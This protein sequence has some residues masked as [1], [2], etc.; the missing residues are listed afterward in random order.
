MHGDDEAAVWL[1]GI[2]GWERTSAPATGISWVGGRHHCSA[3]GKRKRRRFVGGVF[4]QRCYCAGGAGGLRGTRVRG[5]RGGA[6][7]AQTAAQIPGC[8]RY[9]GAAGS[10][11]RRVYAFE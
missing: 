4:V 1:Y 5:E 8:G 7:R 3:F 9:A 6:A 2:V 11:E 10:A